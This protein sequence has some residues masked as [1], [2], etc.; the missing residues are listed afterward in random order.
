MAEGDLHYST[1][2]A[3]DANVRTGRVRR[4]PTRVPSHTFRA[5]DIGGISDE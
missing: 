2:P 4:G 3:I 5:D 1:C